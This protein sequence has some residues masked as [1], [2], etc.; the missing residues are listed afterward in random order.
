MAQLQANYPED[1]RFVYR[2][3][4]L[5][6]I[7]DKALLA[8]QAAEAAGLQGKFWEMHDFL[9]G[10]YNTW[11]LLSA[12]Q[13]P[14][15]VIDNAAELGLDKDQFASDLTSDAMV[16]K[17]QAAWDYGQQ[18]GLPGTPFVAINNVPYQG[19]LDYASFERIIDANK[20][21]VHQYTECPPMVIDPLK[22]YIATIETE[23]GNIV[24]E[25]FPDVAPMTVNSFVFLAREGWFDGVTF[26]RVL[27]GFMAQGGDPSG[28][29]M[30][31]PGYAFKNETTP[32]LVF[33]RAGLMAMA[34]S[35]PD[36]NGSQFFITYAPAERLNGS[37]T[38]FGEV[39]EG[40]DVAES[41]TPRDPSQAGALPPGD[42]IITITIEEK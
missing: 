39:L 16:A 3:F 32:D 29:G 37:Y 26:H 24:V 13:F 7:H 30:G 1:V 12:D 11:T 14:A 15:W 22:Q 31:G 2:H 17:A 5:A 40:M 33:D 28:S 35:G 9:F 38:I 27:P 10:N 19:N 4:P 34:N 25:L 23:K 8:A 41:L 18:I 36:T 20:L 42:K 6:S 21:T